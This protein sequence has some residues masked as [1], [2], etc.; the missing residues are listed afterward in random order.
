MA[1][2]P[3]DIQFLNNFLILHSRKEYFD[4]P[5]PAKRRHLLRL[6]L[7]NPKSQ[8]RAINKIHL[9]T[10]TPLPDNIDIKLSN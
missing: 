1:F 9:Y 3:G 4:D 7:D 5:D 8:R 10:D 6:W 2:E